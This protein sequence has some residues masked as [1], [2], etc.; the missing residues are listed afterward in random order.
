MCTVVKRGRTVE[1]SWSNVSP[2]ADT[3]LWSCSWVKEEIC[4]FWTLSH[5]SDF[6]PGSIPRAPR[7]SQSNPA[8]VIISEWDVLQSDFPN[9]CVYFLFCARLYSASPPFFFGNYCN[10]SSYI[11]ILFWCFSMLFC[12]FS[13]RC[14][15]QVM[16][17]GEVVGLMGSSS[18]GI[19]RQGIACNWCD[20]NLLHNGSRSLTS[21]LS[22]LKQPT[23]GKTDCKDTAEGRKREVSCV[24]RPGIWPCPG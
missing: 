9:Y 22:H 7:E 4:L 17:E 20:F 11:F 8:I 5:Y 21:D 6:H 23:E 15:S 24:K 14:C 2:V 19:Q 16:A 10:E 18:W 12:D 3:W 1:D 13:R